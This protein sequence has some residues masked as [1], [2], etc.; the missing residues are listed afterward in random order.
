MSKKAKP[1]EPLIEQMMRMAYEHAERVLVKHGDERSSLVP[2]FAVMADGKLDVIATPWSNDEEKR[3]AQMLVR[4]KIKL[5]HAEAY[6]FVSE[7]WM[8][9][10]DK[11]EYPNAQAYDGIMPSQSERRVEVVCVTAAAKSETGL[12][13]RFATWT[14]ERNASGRI[15]ALK[16]MPQ[17][18]QGSDNVAGTM[19]TLMD[20]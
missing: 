9:S 10:V 1:G 12:D 3:M 2:I 11:S 20:D 5:N 13:K 14:I 15:V 7:A 17:P 4:A 8:L 6:S 18:Y 19:T 16:P